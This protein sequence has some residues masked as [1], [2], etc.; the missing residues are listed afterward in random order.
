M[1]WA[2]EEMFNIVW[3]L[4]AVVED[5]ILTDSALVQCP[6]LS[7]ARVVRSFLVSSFSEMLING[8]GSSNTTFILRLVTA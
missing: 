8:G 2:I 1:S 4:A 6:D 5:S 3:C 7:W